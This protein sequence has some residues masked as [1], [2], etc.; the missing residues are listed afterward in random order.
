MAFGFT[1]AVCYYHTSSRCHIA[2]N[3]KAT[4]TEHRIGFSI[5]DLIP[6]DPDEMKTFFWTITEGAGQMLDTSDDDN[7]PSLILF[8]G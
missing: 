2:S 1:I 3:H 8:E 5:L 6:A 4:Q 7:G